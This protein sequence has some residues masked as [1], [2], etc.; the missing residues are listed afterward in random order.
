MKK[1]L[2]LGAIG[3]DIPDDKSIIDQLQ[4]EQIEE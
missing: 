1:S 2:K 3:T 4:R